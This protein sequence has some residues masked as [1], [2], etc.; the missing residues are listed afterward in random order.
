MT[1]PGVALIVSTTVLA[2]L[3]DLRRFSRGRELAAYAGLSPSQGSSGTSIHGRTRMCKLGNRKVR[4]V[5]YLAAMTAIRHP[6]PLKDAYEAMVARGKNRK[7]A[8]GAV[9]RRLLLLMRALLASERDHCVAG[10]PL[11]AA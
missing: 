5:L 8:L 6:G 7:S 2:L 11:S 3:G 4:H 10:K 9:M 1:I